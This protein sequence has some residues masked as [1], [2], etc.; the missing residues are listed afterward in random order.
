MVTLSKRRA[1][2]LAGGSLLFI[3][4]TLAARAQQAPLDS[5][6]VAL[7]DIDVTATRT[8]QPLALSASAI[9]VIPAAE[10]ERR[11]ATGLADA[12]RGTPGLD[13]YSSGGVGTVTPVYLRGATAGQTL[14]MLD[15]VRINDPSGTDGFADLGMLN[16][17][18]VER[19]EVLR[20]PQSALY[21]SDA[22][23]GVINIITK[24]GDGAP[25]GSA[26][27]EGGSYGTV[28]SRV[29][30]SGSV[31]DWSWSFAVDALHADAPPRYGY[32]V[33]GPLSYGYGVVA[34]PAPD[35]SE[36][37]NKLG[38]S[39]QL[40]YRVNDDLVITGGFNGHD[41]GAR[42][43]NPGAFAPGDV[44]G[45]FNRLLSTLVQGYLRI[46]DDAFDKNLHSRL[47]VFG[48]NTHRDVWETEVFCTIA[49]PGD[50]KI[51]YEGGRYGAEYQGDV[52][53][54]A[55][56]LLTFGG[57]TETE[58]LRTTAQDQ[59]GAADQ[60]TLSARQTTNSLFAQHQFT[61]L[62]RLDIS[63]G[64]RMDATGGVKIF[65]TWRTTAAYRLEETGTKLRGTVG[66]GA[67]APSL[68][69]RFSLYGD[70]DLRPEDS[71]GYDFGVDQKLFDDRLTLSATY[72][73]SDYNNLI[74]YGYAATCAASQ[75]Y[76]CYYNVG[77]SRIQ[78]LELSAE[79]VVFPEELRARLSYTNMD[80]R[81]LAT[82][83][84][85]ARRP[86]NK[87]SAALI[88]T[89]VP[90]LELEGRVTVVGANP[91]TNF[92][93]AT[94][95]TTP[96]VLPAYARIDVYANY[97]LDH[98][99]SVF[100]RIENLTDARYQEIANYGGLGRSVYGGVKLDW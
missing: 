80:A 51:G 79:A 50:C 95:V 11:G 26:S 88:Y 52:K 17:A 90:R 53:L 28:H 32:R 48:N 71:I 94:Y 81:N 40:R 87:G 33:K 83:D 98:G 31:G 13:I 38:G 69:Q 92:N 36:P 21:G 62:D 14:V 27:V 60:V 59:P 55:Y 85:I 46:D 63:F 43:D 2:L 74:N 34:G 89:G 56:G 99:L 15:G 19:V 86:H 9:S 23:G 54:G 67:K 3:V 12:L 25:H 66:T 6:F 4:S 35:V 22:M 64:G 30:E 73:N 49:Y 42:F 96:V 78:G 82:G 7:G 91:D 24:Q 84:V 45:G 93:N 20:G 1:A 97:K 75:I 39:A 76:G 18:N 72:F 57:K 29:Q 61:V 58:T 77:R 16:A 41:T 10:V 37:T 100:G 70:P 8:E 44:Y 5:Q 65:N 68:Y 47:T